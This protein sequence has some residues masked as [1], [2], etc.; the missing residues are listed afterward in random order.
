MV[1]ALRLHV[2]KGEIIID[3][4]TATEDDFNAI[5]KQKRI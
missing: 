4:A 5:K 1:V 2:K 3:A